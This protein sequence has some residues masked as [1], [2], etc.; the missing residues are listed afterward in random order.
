MAEQT[1]EE[2]VDAVYSHAAELMK[3]GMPAQEI[4]SNLV[5]Q[6]L[7][8]ESADA[9]VSNLFAARVKQQQTQG[10]KN[11]GFGAL[12]L[13]GGIVVT[14]ATYGATSDGGK[15]VVAWGAMLVGG[16]QFIQGV[17]QFSTAN[18]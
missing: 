18:S 16:V 9:V 1:Q 5:E 17:Y 4:K 8:A 11:I 14:V 15:Y 7:D 10:L 13:V 3:E 2:F 12:W 6:G